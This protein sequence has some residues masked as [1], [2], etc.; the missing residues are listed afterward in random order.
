MLTV[1][2]FG[3]FAFEN[4]IPFI[5]VLILSI[6]SIVKYEKNIR[7]WVY[8]DLQQYEARQAEF[9]FTRMVIVLTAICIVSGIR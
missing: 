4:V 3:V 2:L 1:Y 9:R 8:N 5:I 6:A 7:R